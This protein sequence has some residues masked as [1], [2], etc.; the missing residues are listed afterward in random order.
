MRPFLTGHS[1]TLVLAVTTALLASGAIAI[2]A[3]SRGGGVIHACASKADGSLRY[4]GSGNCKGSE[5]ALAWNRRGR[6]GVA[7][8]PGRNGIS[9]PTSG[10]RV[11][12]HASPNPAQAGMQYSVTITIENSGPNPSWVGLNSNIPTGI[13][14]KPPTSSHGYCTQTL[15]PRRQFTCAIG[16]LTAGQTAVVTYTTDACIET[17]DALVASI[18]GSSYD[19][20]PAAET[21]RLT[22][23]VV[24]SGGCG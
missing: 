5:R 22:L 10:L 16:I 21:A 11:T 15:D 9:A 7:G 2:A 23:P 18:T 4:L 17:S 8:H 3:S 24:G 6:T 19:P 12:L 14:I 20:N 13:V 1:R